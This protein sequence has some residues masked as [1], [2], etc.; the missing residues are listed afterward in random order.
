MS[1]VTEAFFVDVSIVQL[2]LML[3]N[4]SRAQLRSANIQSPDDT[5]FIGLLIY[6]TI[7]R[8]ISN[9]LY[10]LIPYLFV[11]ELLLL[12]LY[13]LARHKLFNTWKKKQHRNL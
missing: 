2:Y 7:V 11:S 8:L 12:C 1:N 10:F 4:D 5:I 3:T 9:A 13:K 6:W